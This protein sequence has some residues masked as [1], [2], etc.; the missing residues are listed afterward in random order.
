MTSVVAFLETPRYRVSTL[1]SHLSATATVP[2]T[3]MVANSTP[4]L[5][6]L[7][8]PSTVTSPVKTALEIPTTASLETVMGTAKP[9]ALAT[10]AV[11]V[12]VTEALVLVRSSVPTG[13]LVFTTLPARVAVVVSLSP[14]MA[15][16]AVMVPPMTLVRAK[17]PSAV[18]TVPLTLDLSAVKWMLNRI[19]LPS[20]VN[21]DFSSLACCNTVSSLAPLNSPS[22]ML[23]IV[24]G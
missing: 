3:F 10:S 5:S 2:V 11:P 21:I 12:T 17:L 19:T 22:V 16:S 20:F 23:M 14:S 1:A 13:R 4:A 9:V 24:G 6:T 15:V 18:V 7:R 8:V